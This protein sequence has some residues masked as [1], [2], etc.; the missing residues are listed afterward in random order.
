MSIFCLSHG[1]VAWAIYAWR[2][3]LVFHSI[4]KITSIWIHFMP[5]VVLYTLRWLYI[6]FDRRGNQFP[7]SSTS[8]QKL[9]TDY[10]KFSFD[11]KDPSSSESFGFMESML[12][13]MTV[14]LLWQALYYYYINIRQAEK[15][16]NRLRATSFTWLVKKNPCERD[17]IV[18]S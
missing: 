10:Y 16:K 12:V 11:P 7:S 5:A 4:D 13:S 8:S 14:Y 6:P 17:I 9:Y 2:N 18:L 15:L 1:P 3:S